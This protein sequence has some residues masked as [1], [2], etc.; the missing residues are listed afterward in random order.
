MATSP[1]SSTRPGDDEVEDGVFELR[2]GRESDPLVGVLALAGDERETH[3]GDGTRERQT[4][5]LGRQRG[6]V[7]REGVVELP[8]SDREHGDDDLDLVAEAVDE[9]R[10]Q[11]PVDEAAHEDGLGRGATLA[12]EERAGDLAG[13]VRA[14]FDV[15]GQ[16]EE[17]ESFTRVL[18]GAGGRQEHRLFVEVGGDSALSLL[19]EASGLEP[20]GTGAETAVVENGFSGGNFWTFQEVPPSLFRLAAPCGRRA[21]MR[22][23]RNRQ[24]GRADESAR[25]SRRLATSRRPPGDPTGSPPQGTSV[26]RPAP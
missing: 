18:A 17:V 16:R 21:D 2:D 13:G 5:D 19:S 25:K 4:R 20:D 23:S 9:R 14:L 26:C 6:G 7:D 22:R 1:S 3:T 24:K 12:A 8:G 11:R 10:A 15:D